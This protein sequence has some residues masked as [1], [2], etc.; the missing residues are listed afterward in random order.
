[1][2]V[3]QSGERRSIRAIGAV[4]EE[5][6]FGVMMLLSVAEV[7][8]EASLVLSIIAIVVVVVCCCFWV[9]GCGYRW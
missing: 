2:G 5:E 4:V 6:V 8:R 9:G 1:M 7:T 3:E